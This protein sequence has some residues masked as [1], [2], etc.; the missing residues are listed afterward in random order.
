MQ[1]P[2]HP[3]CETLVEFST[4]ICVIFSNIFHDCQKEIVRVDLP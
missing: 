1:I 2:G 4:R 3:L